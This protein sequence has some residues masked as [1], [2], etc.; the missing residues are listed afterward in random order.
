MVLTR[1]YTDPSEY[2]RMLIPRNKAI[3][4][5]APVDMD[6]LIFHEGN[7]LERSPASVHI[8]FVNVANLFDPSKNVPCKETNV[9]YAL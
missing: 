5:W 1:G 8:I 4:K 6:H 7:I 2:D 9:E 3:A